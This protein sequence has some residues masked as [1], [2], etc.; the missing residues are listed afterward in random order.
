MHINVV[1]IHFL[2]ITARSVSLCCGQ[3]LLSILSYTKETPLFE[4]YLTKMTSLFSYS[5]FK[6]NSNTVD[7]QSNIQMCNR[8][9][10]HFYTSPGARHDGARFLPTTCFACPP[11]TS[12]LVTVGVLRVCF[13]LCLLT[14]FIFFPFVV[15]FLSSNK[16]EII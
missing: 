2:S 3:I 10:Q 14:S 1:K 13:L 8:G 12:P 5:F 4:K 16:S 15:C 9:V 7:I 6:N 11:Y